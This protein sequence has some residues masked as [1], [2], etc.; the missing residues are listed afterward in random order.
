MTLYPWLVGAWA[1]VLW[2]FT[3]GVA[4]VLFA[5]F[6]RELAGE[7]TTALFPTYF[8]AV[9]TLGVLATG[10]LWFRRRGPRDN[11]ALGLQSLALAALAAIPLLIQPAIMQHAPGTP[12]WARWHGISM[13]LNLFSLIAV[14]VASLLV[15][16]RRKE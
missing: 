14:P 16:A 13:A 3:F 8:V 10:T 1:A 2:F 9:I 7:I 6:P 11:W 15:F 5:A 12:E 4:R